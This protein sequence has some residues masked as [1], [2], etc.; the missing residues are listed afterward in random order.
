MGVKK[1]TAAFKTDYATL[2]LKNLPKNANYA[3]LGKNPLKKS[4][5]YPL[6]LK[7][8]IEKKH[9]YFYEIVPIS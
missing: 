3:S 8:L 6:K 9:V 7:S 5:S 2:L 1:K 4:A